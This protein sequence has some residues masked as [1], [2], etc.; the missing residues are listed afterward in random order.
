MLPVSII[1]VW[2]AIA[3]VGG[4]SF[5]KIGN[6]ESNNQAN[7]LPASAESTKVQAIQ[8]RFYKSD[9][10]PAVILVTSP[11]KFKPQD[12]GSLSYLKPKLANVSGVSKAAASVIGPIPSKDGRAVEFVVQIKASADISKVVKNLKQIMHD[13]VA[14][15]QRR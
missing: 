4:P 11:H 1:I 6:V 8:N 7:F 12:L 10:L 14:N 5:G 3:G 13:N 2:L 9:T 15:N